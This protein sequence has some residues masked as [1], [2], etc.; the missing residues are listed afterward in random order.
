[1]HRSLHLGLV[2]DY[3]EVQQIRDKSV[4][5]YHEYKNSSIAIFKF[6]KKDKNKIL[7]DMIGNVTKKKEHLLKLII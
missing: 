5:F 2:S 1:M 3:K 6:V 4:Y 7:L